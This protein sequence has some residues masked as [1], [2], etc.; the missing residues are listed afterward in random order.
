VPFDDLS[1]GVQVGVGTESIRVDKAA[2]WVATLHNKRSLAPTI[3]YG[4]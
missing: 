4:R 2:H 1:E 3:I